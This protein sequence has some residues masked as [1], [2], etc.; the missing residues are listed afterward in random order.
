MFYIEN[1]SKN[2]FYEILIDKKVVSLNS[3]KRLD[4]N[5]LIKKN[6]GINLIWLEDVNSFPNYIVIRKSMIEDFFAWVWS[7]CQEFCP[8]SSITRIVTFNE[9]HQICNK[10][11]S[12]LSSIYDIS[13]SMVVLEVMAH[14]YSAN[15]DISFLKGVAYSSTFS[16]LAAQ[17]II[18]YGEISIKE[19]YHRWVDIRNCSGQ[20]EIKINLDWFVLIWEVIK[21]YYETANN[22]KELISCI[23][24]NNKVVLDDIKF[25][26]IN[27]LKNDNLFESVVP[28][29][30]KIAIIENVFLKIQNMNNYALE[31]IVG[32]AYLIN[33]IDDGSLTHINYVL[34]KYKL[35]PELIPWYA[36]FAS[37]S[38][39]KSLKKYSRR[40]YILFIN[41]LESKTCVSDYPNSDMNYYEFKTI[42][43]KNMN[44]SKF[45]FNPAYLKVEVTVNSAYCLKNLIKHNYEDKDVEN[46]DA[47]K[48]EMKR[49][50]AD[51][52]RKV[53]NARK[54]LD[55]LDDLL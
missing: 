29:E 40:D 49:V 51:A 9:Y 3:V 18:N 32:L 55:K 45:A 52:K 8:L 20:R 43:T 53:T 24:A 41:L 35:F 6:N 31:D 27:Y 39:R 10:Q 25:K 34:S 15:A 37:K 47:S 12:D 1:F 38:I 5:T 26:A 17:H 2:E 42:Y 23:A 22:S 50:V 54:I 11:K 44:C 19:L 28:L 21:E 48:R 33:Q 30:N 7:Y 4:N 14:S 13:F 46:S 16:F 36:V